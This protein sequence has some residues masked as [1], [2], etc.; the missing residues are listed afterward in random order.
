PDQLCHEHGEYRERSGT[1]RALLPWIE[2]VDFRVCPGASASACVL[3]LSELGARSP[4]AG[5]SNFRISVFGAFD[6]RPSDFI[7]RSGPGATRTGSASR[8][9]STGKPRPS[10]RLWPG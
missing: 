8:A 1:H 3:H 10:A 5:E 4:D 9:W 2:K 6:L 7:S